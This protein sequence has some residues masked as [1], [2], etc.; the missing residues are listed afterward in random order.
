MRGA[1]Q[2]STVPAFLGELQQANWSVSH[3]S[4]PRSRPYTTALLITV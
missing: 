3:P 4:G 1:G 2:A